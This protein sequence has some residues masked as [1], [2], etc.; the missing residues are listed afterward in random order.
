[1]NWK[2]EEIKITADHHGNFCANVD[3]V[4]I[5]ADTLEEARGLVHRARLAAKTGMR[6]EKELVLIHSM[7]CDQ[8]TYRGASARSTNTLLVTKED[9]EKKDLAIG[10]QGLG[11]IQVETE[12]AT[13]ALQFQRDIDRWEKE[14]AESEKK[15]EEIRDRNL[16]DYTSPGY[17]ANKTTAALDLHD[18]MLAHIS[19]WAS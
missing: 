5:E 3:G 13:E 12:D 8:V 9:G 10:W 14:I 17:S 15:I 19:A 1:M 16:L 6:I 2:H 4:E 11:V 18:A 7:R